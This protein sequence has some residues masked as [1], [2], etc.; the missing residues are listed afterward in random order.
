V[1]GTCDFS[2]Y[3]IDDLRVILTEVCSRDGYGKLINQ[4]KTSVR[5]PLHKTPTDLRMALSSDAKT[6]AA[7]EDLTPLARNEWTCWVISAKQE[8]TRSHRIQRAVKELQAGKR[9]PCCW[10]GCPHRR[11][12]AKKWFEKR[13]R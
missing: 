6:R 2:S 12:G 7:W 11:P 1:I 13:A 3:F 5:G 10:P 9:R 4:S 8:T